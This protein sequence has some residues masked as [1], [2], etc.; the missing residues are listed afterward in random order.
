MREMATRKLA[1]EAQ[2]ECALTVRVVGERGRGG[3]MVDGGLSRTVI[4][5]PVTHS[6][7]IHRVSCITTSTCQRIL[8]LKII[9]RILCVFHLL[10]SKAVFQV[11]LV[12]SA[13]AAPVESCLATG[14]ID[15]YI[16]ATTWA[17]G[18]N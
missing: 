1:A 8:A 14:S 18:I 7:H 4:F 5:F 16:L 11:R 6:T 15:N 10:K 9:D 13:T 2:L 17:G 12:I 3:A